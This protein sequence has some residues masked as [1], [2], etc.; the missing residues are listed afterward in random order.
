MEIQNTEQNKT[1][2]QRKMDTSANVKKERTP[3]GSNIPELKL[4]YRAIGIIT[5]EHCHKNSPVYQ[6][7]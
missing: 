2:K 1:N 7:Y 4:I 3:G 5:A 6:R